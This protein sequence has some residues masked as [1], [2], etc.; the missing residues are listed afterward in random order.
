MSVQD[1]VQTQTI[2][3]PTVTSK[4]SG[5]L[6]RVCACGQHTAGSSECEECKKKREGISQRAAVK[7][8]PMNQMPPT[9]HEGLPSTNQP[10]G[11]A[12]SSRPGSRYGPEFSKISL[13]PATPRTASAT[14]KINKPHDLYEQEAERVANQVLSIPDQTTQGISYER[15]KKDEDRALPQISKT[16]PRIQ[17]WLLET[18][19]EYEIQQELERLGIL[20]TIAAEIAAAVHALHGSGQPLP[21]SLRMFFEAR[22]GVDLS[23]V[24]LHTGNAAAELV[25]MVNAKAF[26][27]GQDILFGAG[28]FSPDTSEGTMLLAH[29]LTHTIQ[30]DGKS[31][32]PLIKNQPSGLEKADTRSVPATENLT[33]VSQ[34]SSLPPAANTQ[35]K[36]VSDAAEKTSNDAEEQ[37]PDKDAVTAQSSTQETEGEVPGE[38][39]SAKAPASPKE[40]LEYQAVV[41]QL[42]KKGKRQKMPP[43]IR[44]SQVDVVDDSQIKEVAKE[45]SG[46][47]KIQTKSA[48]E[49][50]PTNLDEQTKKRAHL[51]QLAEKAQVNLTVVEFMNQFDAATAREYEKLQ[52]KDIA[53]K[54][55]DYRDAEESASKNVVEQTQTHSNPLRSEAARDPLKDPTKVATEVPEIKADSPGGAPTIKDAKTAAPKPKTDAEISLDDKSRSLDDALANHNVNGQTVNID[56]GSLPLP[57]SGEKSFDEAG[58]AKRKAQDEIEKAGPTYR[59]EERKI[60]SAAQVS[61]QSL[62]NSGLR[63]FNNSRSKSFGGVFNTQKSHESTI[64]KEKNRVFGIFKGFYDVA[65]GGVERELKQLDTIGEIFETIITQTEA[66]F[67]E[68][69]RVELEYVYP[70][71]FFD[72]SD[73]AT[74]HKTE[75]QKKYEVLI[76][77]RNEKLGLDEKKKKLA[78]ERQKLLLREKN[79]SSQDMNKVVDLLGEEIAFKGKEYFSEGSETIVRAFGPNS[80]RALYEKA[81][82]QTKAEYV[83]WY[84]DFKKR[85]FVGEVKERVKTEVATIVVDALNKAKGHIRKGKKDTEEAF[86]L[87]KPE[88]QKEVQAAY[89]GAISNYEGLEESVDERKNEIINDMAR[90]YN[91]S[92]GQ[93]RAT[94]DKIKE[95]VLTSW[96]EKAWNKLKA[97]VNAIIDFA[98]QIGALLGRLAH[99][100]GD[101]ISSPRRFFSNLVS[102]IGQGFSTFIDRIG[103]FLTTAFFDWLRGTSGLP[104]Q[105][106]K[107]W[108]PSGI[109]SLFTQLLGLSTETIWQRM[110][111]VYN[112]TIANA[113]RRGEV[114]LERGLEIFAIIKNEGLGG[115]W[116][117]IKESLGSILDETLERI[118][119]T[120]LFAAIKKVILEIGKMLVPGGGFIAIAEKVIRLLQFIVEARDRI[121]DLIEKF[122]DAVEM[123]VKGNVTG[124]VKHI[125]DA[126]TQFITIALDF[127][128]TVFG[129]GNL[130]E[131]VQRIIGS[132]TKL[133]LRGI[134]WV[135]NKLK[136]LV[137]R[138]FGRTGKEPSREERQDRKQLDLEETKEHVQPEK[139]EKAQPDI[140][141]AKQ[142]VRRALDSHLPQ[143]ARQVAEVEKVLAG[144]ETKVKPALTDL[145]AE[146][147]MPGELKAE[148]ATGFLVKAK[149]QTGKDS[150]IDKVR[151]SQ[152]GTVLSH[153]ERW[154]LGVKGVKRAVVHLEKRGISEET[155]KS[156]FSRWQTEFGFT[157]LTLNTEQSPWVIT[158]AMSEDEV[159]T[160]ITAPVGTADIENAE[161]IVTP[162]PD[163]VRSMQVRADPLTRRAWEKGSSKTTAS[164]VGWD[165]ATVLN[166]PPNRTKW[167]KA[168]L[169]HHK[170]GGPN[171]WWNLVPARALANSPG[172]SNVEGHVIGLLKDKTKKFQSFWYETN[173]TY[174]EDPHNDF[175]DKISI[176]YAA[177]FTNLATGKTDE[178]S[179]NK[180]VKSDSPGDEDG[181]PLDLNLL[182]RDTLMEI[183]Q[184]DWAT[185]DAIYKARQLIPFKNWKDFVDR[186]PLDEED[187]KDFK[188]FK[189]NNLLKFG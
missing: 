46:S 122:V 62:V 44:K 103:E 5:L 93:L 8:F 19:D 160:T 4:A 28:A 102:G 142:T 138:V 72:Y 148:G 167:V 48:A 155:I 113:F 175:A 7:T 139:Q 106:P 89:E 51:D 87:L 91:K 78:E 132:I 71:G 52:G 154:Q 101:I 25:K 12:A 90:A 186:S 128:V 140:I 118:K 74:D 185:A 135:L 96:W 26:T 50:P 32:Q 112:K 166:V 158:G 137:F 86:E 136:P 177:K 123:A 150:I 63:G 81:V 45:T 134:D 163:G 180:T 27:L 40:D 119:E 164:V 47:K 189:D 188:K 83:E 159:V 178:K 129:L 17:R 82:D 34:A 127:L 111:V 97:V 104:I 49:L 30:Q 18:Y 85:W 21:E 109:F 84:F 76:K 65:K 179:D 13:Y 41:E 120:V 116:E 157:K 39:T 31:T 75:V 143:G 144:I 70:P 10:I 153:E 110:E 146:E 2:A 107:E 184:L 54:N 156:Q 181:F 161:T 108:S 64:E 73:F 24:R 80:D 61:T 133:I 66:K 165:K 141:V 58:E 152:K 124:I 94:F 36:E 3:K 14:L 171:E 60:L 57:I 20:P 126:L 95:D 59:A 98:K 182:G 162:K 9:V 37:L 174:H 121:A 33:N 77:E 35:P 88:V 16:S 168:H 172:M 43:I 22:F 55:L 169:L 114:L 15:K 99:L 29:E 69:V 100:V 187:L 105:L 130:K 53:F 68:D 149:L 1:T 38:S 11:L 92:V 176:S 6:Q 147:F 115:L 125:T 145:R 117:H 170:L 151:F 183:F 42:D 23:R 173:V 79:V 131:K 56:E 67:R